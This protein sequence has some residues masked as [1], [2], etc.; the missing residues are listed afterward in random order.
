MPETALNLLMKIT[1]RQ[2]I[3]ELNVKVSDDEVR[4]SIEM[5]S[6][7]TTV[8]AAL[9]AALSSQG[10]T[11]EQYF[12]QLRD[13]I[14]KLKL[15]SMEVRSKIHVS[16]SEIKEYYEANPDQF[17]E[18]EEFKARH[19]F[20]RVNEAAPDADIKKA[21]QTALHVLAEAQSGKDFIEL[22]K[23]Y[24]EDPAARKDGGDLGRFKKGDMQ[25][26]L[27]R[28]IINLK[29]GQ[30]KRTVYTPL[31]LHIIKLEER[32]KGKLKPLETVKTALMDTLYRKKSE[33]RFNR[34]PRNCAAD[35]VLTSRNSR[36]TSD[37][38]L[39]LKTKKPLTEG[40][41][42]FFVLFSC[43]LFATTQISQKTHHTELL[44][45][46]KMGNFTA[47]GS[48]FPFF[49]LILQQQKLGVLRLYGT[50]EIFPAIQMPTCRA[51]SG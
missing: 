2:K 7:R 1:D 48:L 23:Q 26:E 13:Q 8:P 41:R 29:P 33:E 12:S 5:S 16:D 39:H 15:V 10:I 28:A 38:P 51:T 46:D 9:V 50:N 45:T 49:H 17:S 37:F 6:A 34:W 24:S 47:H 22:A 40:Q 32:M 4:Q 18:E 42:L 44:F 19:I 30:I 20:F 21:M 3:K 25:P 14:E 35:P 27:E 36:A 43:K 31:G 11:Y